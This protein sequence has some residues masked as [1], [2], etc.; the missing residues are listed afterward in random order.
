MNSIIPWV[1][2]KG[3]YKPKYASTDAAACDLQSAEDVVLPPGG[4]W[5]VSTGLSLEIQVGFMGQ[6]CPRSGLA[7]KHGVTVLNSPG[8]L[9]ADFR[10]EVKVVLINHSSSE[11]SVKK[12][13][14]IAQ[15]IFVPSFRGRLSHAD[16]LSDTARGLG[17]FGSTGV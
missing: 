11:Y 14:R 5:A 17:A 15:L 16:E 3:D 10:G 1:K 7:L 12:G 13:D 9:D 8:I 4:W 2:Y 6:I